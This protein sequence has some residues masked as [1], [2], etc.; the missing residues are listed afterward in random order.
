VADSPGWT[1]FFNPTEKRVKT[2]APQTVL[3]YTFSL[4]P[5]WSTHT[6]GVRTGTLP[7]PQEN[8]MNYGLHPLD[9]DFPADTEDLSPPVPQ[10]RE[11]LDNFL[12]VSIFASVFA[13]FFT[14]FA[15]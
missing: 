13:F 2:F 10:W 12:A 11:T 14:F 8:P 15:N 5:E 9:P 6:L 4:T 3:P 7:A 1:V